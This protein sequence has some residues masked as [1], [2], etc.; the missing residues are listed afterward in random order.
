MWFR[1]VASTNCRCALAFSRRAVLVC[2][3][4]SRYLGGEVRLRPLRDLSNNTV[5]IVDPLQTA[6]SD[7]VIT[8]WQ[9]YSTA[10]SLYHAVYLQVPVPATSP[11]EVLRGGEETGGHD[12]PRQ[13]PLPQTKF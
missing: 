9:M 5:V 13:I 2:V 4:E 6:L 1:S 8:A 11:R 10:V 7:G 12:P 3:V